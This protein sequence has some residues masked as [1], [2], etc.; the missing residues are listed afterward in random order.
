MPTYISQALAILTGGTSLHSEV[1]DIQ[2][3]T[4]NL[5]PPRIRRLPVVDVGAH[6]GEDLVIPSAKLG[7]RVYAFE[8]WQGS[9]L[10]MER[11]VKKYNLTG[12]RSLHNFTNAPPGTVFMPSRTAVSNRTGKARLTVSPMYNG[13]A[14]TLGGTKSMP[15]KY[16]AIA[17]HQWVSTVRLSD[18]LAD[19]IGGV[20]LLKIDAQ[21][22]EY[23]ILKGAADY[24]RRRPVY[25]IMLE[26]T[27]FALTAQGV[28][29]M[30]LLKLL[31]EDFG[32]QCFDGRKFRP[33]WFQ[34]QKHK[35]LAMTL[36]EFNASYNPE[37][38]RHFRFGDW[39]D[40]TCLRF[41][42]MRRL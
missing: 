41:D 33:V 23:H 40:L 16:A 37:P 20:Y 24:I 11:N 6:F 29:P 3:L 15:A 4:Y 27:P 17:T 25:M 35:R 2:A 10:E 8:P 14:N 21:G 13:V 5:L 32:Y 39:T 31:T 42:L 22:H 30:A 26:F 7:H 18:V 36:E 28:D 1:K 34:R 12:T 38:R 9:Y 19:E